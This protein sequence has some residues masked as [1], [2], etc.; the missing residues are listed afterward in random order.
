MTDVIAQGFE[1]R[2]AE[3][4]AAFQALAQKKATEFEKTATGTDSSEDMR[5]VRLKLRERVLELE[6]EANQMHDVLETMTKL[7]ED[8]Q[9]SYEGQLSQEEDNL[10]KQREEIRKMKN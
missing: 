10:K 2:E 5:K 9:A 3:H 8:K 1:H 6:V 7:L 4:R